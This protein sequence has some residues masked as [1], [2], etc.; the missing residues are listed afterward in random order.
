M[1]DLLDQRYMPL[2]Q[3]MV[4]AQG[5]WRAISK[6][7]GLLPPMAVPVLVCVTYNL[8][9]DEWHTDRWVD[10]LYADGWLIWPKR[11]DL[12][13]EPTHWM[14]LPTPPAFQPTPAPL[15]TPS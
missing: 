2:N 10:E 14:P 5:G 11:I 9:A 3:K 13:E 7:R 15:D 12:P 6:S 8:S 4:E 1:G